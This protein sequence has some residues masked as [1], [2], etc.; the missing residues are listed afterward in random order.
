MKLLDKP[1]GV[2]LQMAAALALAVANTRAQTATAAT[3]AAPHVDITQHEK[4][5]L[6]FDGQRV[7][8]RAFENIPYV[9]HPVDARYQRMNIYV[10]EAYFSGGSVGGYTAETAPIF[11]PNNVGGYMPAEPG[12]PGTRRGGMADTISAALAHGLVV[13][14]PGTRGRTLKDATG[15]NT[16]KAPAAI[17][18]L[19]AAVRFLRF[20]DQNL[21]GNANLIISNGT[22]AGGA[23][24]ALLGATGNHPDYEPYLAALGAAPGRDDIFAA[25]CYCPITNLDHA[26][27]AYEWL[28]GDVVTYDNHGSG[29]RLTGEQLAV[30]VELRTL[31][32]DYVNSLGLKNPAG[33]SLTLHPD[34]SGG[35]RD[36]VGRLVVASARRAGVKGPAAEAFPWLRLEAGEPVGLDFAGYVAHAGRMKTPPA[37]DALDLSSGENDLFGDAQINAKHFTTYSITRSGNAGATAD[38]ALIK[39]MNPLPYLNDP[40]ALAAPHWRI[41]HGTIDRDTS[42]AVPAILALTLEARGID[43]DFALTWERGHSGDYDLPELF[44]WIDA[45]CAAA[46]NPADGRQDPSN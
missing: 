18:D 21:P 29:G 26:D 14:A 46:P 41:R 33:E 10:P 23:L 30:A 5:V 22:S 11:L 43:V 27:T 17:V 28:F 2:A 1:A 3:I 34:G 4:R 38:P 15:R 24:S 31:F 32:P 45:I 13:A 36:Y 37:F 42:L 6:E 39:M 40:A 7:V 44:S 9:S 19:K 35:F 25:S 8:Y 16:G 12:K 20:N